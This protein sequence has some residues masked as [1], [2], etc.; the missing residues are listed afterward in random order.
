MANSE[1]KLRIGVEGASEFKKNLENINRQSKTLA[2]EIK[3]AAAAFDTSTTAEEKNRRVKELLDRQI[4]TQQEAINRLQEAVKA[5]SDAEGENGNNTL[6]YRDQLAKAQI[7][8]SELTT[9]AAALTDGI[10]EIEDEMEIGG[11]GADEFQKNLQNIQKQSNTLATEIRAAASAFDTSTS[12]EEKNQRVKELLDKQITVQQQSIDQLKEAVEAYTQSEG[13]NGENTLKY[14]DQL[15]RAEITM[16]D[17]QSRANELAGGV[18]EV[19]EEMQQSGQDAASF[20]DILKANVISDAIMKGLD[21]LVDGIKKVAGA[22]KDA[23]TESAKFADDINT[24]SVTT[25]ISTDTLQEWQYMQGLTDV[26]LDTMTGSLTKLTKNM[27]SAKDGTGTAAESFEAL[28]ISVT[29][30]N[31]E[32]RDNETVFYEI[33]DAL[34]QMSNETERDATSMTIFGKSAQDLNPIIELGADGMKA[35]A[36]EAH[37]M[38][39]VLDK[40]ALSSLSGVQD[41]MDRLKNT[42][43]TLKN[44]LGQALAPTINELADAAQ[45]F[46]GKIDISAVAEKITGFIDFVKEN[47]DTIIA[48]ISGIGAGF[49]TWNVVS[50]VSGLVGA[51]KAFKAANE[52]ASIAQ[53]ALNAVMNANPIGIIITAVSALV[54]AIVVLW[55]TNE[56]FRNAV[57]NAWEAIKNGIQTAVEAVKGAFNSVKDF[58]TDLIAKAK[59][60][61]KD[62][63]QGF[64][65]G[66]RSMIDKVGD[67]AKA[68]A[69]KVTGFLHFSRPDVGPLREYE[70]WMPDMMRGLAAGIRDNSYLL[71]AALTDATRGL[72]VSVNGATVRGV[73]GGNT[74]NIYTQTLNESQ[75]DYLFYRFN[76]KSGAM[77]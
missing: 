44:Q 19:G 10:E 71:D 45:D 11:V 7:T 38:G 25:G 42:S 3:A 70:K 31:G 9:Q 62:L 61:G 2:T 50:M 35:F 20:G 26:S 46:V 22:M 63:I 12:A 8:M 23:I 4:Q 32:L 55:N 13:E 58:I 5:Y 67:A 53:A 6:K 18:D 47:G 74:I 34:G 1:A 52:G 40:D 73:V 72:G 15:A 27:L 56:D 77:I 17:L 16:G 37:D 69:E 75:I 39:Y 51:I 14:R 57:L 49:L 41:S 59:T 24:L 48:I 33:I 30:S 21:L 66:I 76:A 65:D 60:W 64:I 68:I 28:G 54:T 36:D 29:D 43:D